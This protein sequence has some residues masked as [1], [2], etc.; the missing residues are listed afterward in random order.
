MD[1]LNCDKFDKPRRL[2]LGAMDIIDFE[3]TSGVTIIQMSLNPSAT[4]MTTVLTLLWAAMKWEDRGLTLQRVGLLVD[5]FV[6]KGGNF[7]ELVDLCSEIIKES[8][9]FG[10]AAGDSGNAKAGE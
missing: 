9:I 4:S 8:R 1:Y 7:L 5:E 3:K 2:R 10:K 6:T